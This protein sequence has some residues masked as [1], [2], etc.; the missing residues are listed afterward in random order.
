[1]SANGGQIA[2]A[3]A[4]D[5]NRGLF[6]RGFLEDR[7]PEWPEAQPGRYVEL[8]TKISELWERESAGLSSANEAQTE[9]RL[10]RPVLRELGFAYTVQTG[11]ATKLG[12]RQPDYALFVD[13]E[14]RLAAEKADSGSRFATAVAVADAKRFERP[15]R[16]R[17][18]GDERDDP[19]AQIVSYVLSSRVGYGILTNGRIWRLYAAEGS[20]LDGAHYEVDLAAALAAD[21]QAQWVSFAAFFGAAAFRPDASGSCLLDRAVD[22]SRASAVA[23]GESLERQVF[24]AVP[25]IAEGLI[26]G[27]PA[28]PDLLAAAFDHALVFLYRLLFC[29]HAEARG[30]L[31]VSNP[32]YR[33][34]SLRERSQEV[35]RDSAA[36]RVYSSHS[37][38][39]Y[40]DLLVLFDIVD[41]GDPDLA[42]NEYDGGLFSAARH[43]WLV[44]RSVPDRLLAPALDLMARVGGATIDYRDLSPRHLG[45]IY[46]RLLDY[47]LEPAAGGRFTLAPATGRHDSGSY[48]TPDFV[49]DRLVE[50]TLEPLLRARSEALVAAGASSDEA[51]E[52]F[53]GL[54]VLDPAMG[55]G[56]FLVAAGRYIA[57]YVATDPSYGGDLSLEEIE[58]RVA[59]RCLYG[60]DL[61]PM[62]V[63]LARLSLWLSTVSK[64]EPLTFLVNL[65]EGNSLVGVDLGTLISGDG[66]LFSERFGHEARELLHRVDEIRAIEST[67]GSEVH[68][69]ERLAGLAGELRAPIDAYADETVAPAFEAP[70]G[71]FFHWELEFPEVFLSLDGDPRDDAGFDIVIGNPPWVRIQ[72]L[73]RETAAWCRAHYVL[74]SGSFDLYVPFLERGIDLMACGGRLGF[75]VPNKLLKL[76]YARRLRDRLAAKRLVA[77]ILDF[78]DAQLFAGA[79]NYSCLLLLDGTAPDEFGYERVSGTATEV[80]TALAAGRPVP[81]QRYRAR[82]FGADPWVLAVGEEARVLATAASGSA[83]LAEVTEAIFQGLITSDDAVYVLED[84]GTRDGKRVVWSKAS[85]AELELEPDLL[86]PLASGGDVERYAFRALDSLLLFP[87]RR[88]EEGAMR[89]LDEARLAGLP[90]TDAYLRSHEARLRGREKGKMD[91]EGWYAFG[92]TQSLGAHDRPKLGVPRMCL[93][94]RVA[95]DPSGE[96]YLDNVDVNG[97]LVAHD[98]PVWLLTVLLNSR[99]LDFVFRRGSVP[100]RGQHFSANKQ[101]IAPL[102]IRVPDASQS[103]DLDYLGK[104]LYENVAALERER[105]DFRGWLAGELGLPAARLGR[106]AL[107]REPDRASLEELLGTVR[108]VEEVDRDYVAGRAFR[109]LL[110]AEHQPLCAQAT[111][112]RSRLELDERRADDAVFELYRLAADQRA[113]V[114]AEYE[115]GAP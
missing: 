69:K 52:L 72:D 41:K 9:E 90:L 109:R 83:S 107:L 39:I 84:R 112:L 79:T 85:G 34:Y 31:P 28:T 104:R 17:R 2:F 88:D 74:A 30:L 25:L 23:L 20:L 68:E 40:A 71:R 55:S 92:R 67:A 4:A 87:Y 24:G 101:F 93:R 33:R 102:P 62:A 15:L 22:E 14:S 29:L 21:D 5:A 53:L 50:D 54:R 18:A 111:E 49:V 47:R 77:D 65:R 16:G 60:V 66:G 89:L 12:R 97:I 80:R 98:R 35:A 99:L 57:Q 3:L 13:E 59:E 19:E 6:S 32:H 46:E 103:T 86:R 78:G 7:F 76:E 113:L 64:D 43:G 44:G 100:F 51:L 115:S 114:D 105:A 1:M 91:H 75:V 26:G 45:T 94:L 108:S 27:E 56:H 36:G 58:R 73:G 63:E 110:V 96:V 37:T 48:Y 8:R 82:D 11:F 38:E 42:V 81:A 95:A 70:A 61:N 106:S 10:I